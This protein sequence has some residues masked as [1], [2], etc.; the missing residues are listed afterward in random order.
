MNSLL[1]PT[2][3]WRRK[4]AWIDWIEA[5][6]SEENLST[7]PTFFASSEVKKLYQ[8]DAYDLLVKILPVRY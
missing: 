8:N 1:S 6:E 3:A 5:A 2:S 4:C 7:E